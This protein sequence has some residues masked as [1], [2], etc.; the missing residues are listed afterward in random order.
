[1]RVSAGNGSM[2][3]SGAL[4]R[5]GTV[6]LVPSSAFRLAKR[7]CSER[8]T[9]LTWPTVGVGGAGTESTTL[10]LCRW[11]NTRMFSP[12]KASPNAAVSAATAAS[13]V[14]HVAVTASRPTSLCASA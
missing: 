11:I 14:A 8:S 2:S 5:P 1:M 6:G 13:W 4:G 12:S 3:S 9:V 10:P 7:G